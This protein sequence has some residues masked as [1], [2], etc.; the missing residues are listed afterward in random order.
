MKN[1][2]ELLKKYRERKNLSQEQLAHIL[3]VTWLTVQRWE[4]G[5]S[6]PHTSN[7]EKF[8]ALSAKSE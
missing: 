1:L 2:P 6:K 7:L 4:V 5:R 8:L 3:E